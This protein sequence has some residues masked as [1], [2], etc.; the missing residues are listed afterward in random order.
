[1]KKLTKKAMAKA[2]TTKKTMNVS[3]PFVIHRT[4]A[5]VLENH[6]NLL[7]SVN[8]DNSL[9]TNQKFLEIEQTVDVSVS[10]S[11]FAVVVVVPENNGLPEN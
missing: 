4:I 1:M 6:L 11:A 2:L 7:E 10:V 8:I 9:L 5:Q 3:L